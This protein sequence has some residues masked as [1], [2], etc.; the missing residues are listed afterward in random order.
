METNVVYWGFKGIMENTMGTTTVLR[1][2]AHKGALAKGLLIERKRNA[3][4]SSSSSVQSTSSFAME[5]QD[6]GGAVQAHVAALAD[7]KFLLQ[8]SAANA[9]AGPRM[10]VP[11]CPRKR[12]GAP[13][14]VWR[15]GQ[16]DQTRPEAMTPKRTRWPRTM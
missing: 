9:E 7:S 3:V 15:C 13:E 8:G 5:A 14:L 1:S 4:T 12:A 10:W 16:P 11:L 6:M 2:R